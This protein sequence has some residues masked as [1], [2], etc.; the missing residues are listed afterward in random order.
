MNLYYCGGVVCSGLLL[1][2][3]VSMDE[4]VKADDRWA[5]DALERIVIF[6]E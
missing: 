2:N 5:H 4:P 1:V 3:D 6:R